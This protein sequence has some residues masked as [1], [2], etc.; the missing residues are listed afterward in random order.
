VAR[1]VDYARAHRDQ[2]FAAPTPGAQP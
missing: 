1:T 2:L